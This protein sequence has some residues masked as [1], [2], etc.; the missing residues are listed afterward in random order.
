MVWF[1]CCHRTKD[2][3]WGTGSGIDK[4]LVLVPG[5]PMRNSGKFNSSL[6]FTYLIYKMRV[7]WVSNIPSRLDST[8]DTR[9]T[10][11][12]KR[13]PTSRFLR[14]TWDCKFTS[15]HLPGD[16]V[17]LPLQ[18]IKAPSLYQYGACQH[19]SKVSTH[20]IAPG[21]Y[22]CTQA[23]VKWLL[24]HLVFLFSSLTEYTGS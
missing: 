17:L 19:P 14:S 12:N 24:S 22:M 13:K 7:D 16:S 2:M 21:P 18:P 15:F 4:P 1:L 11:Q 10:P 20:I 23:T 6:D 5:L 8:S 3:G 9:T